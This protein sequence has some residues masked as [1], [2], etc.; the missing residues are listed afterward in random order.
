MQYIQ[1]TPDIY[2]AYSIPKLIFLG[3]TKPVFSI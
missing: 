3:V 2:E 1:N